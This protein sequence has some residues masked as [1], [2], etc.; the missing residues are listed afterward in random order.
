MF[1]LSSKLGV[2][3]SDPALLRVSFNFRCNERAKSDGR[4]FNELAAVPKARWQGLPPGRQFLP[5]VP[6]SG[7][8]WSLPSAALIFSRISIT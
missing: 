1:T 7:L 4:D 5:R 2:I 8:P 6:A 3:A